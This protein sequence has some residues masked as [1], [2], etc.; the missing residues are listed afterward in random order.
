MLSGGRFQFMF[1]WW[2]GPTTSSANKKPYTMWKQQP[3]FPSG[4][5][6]TGPRGFTSQCVGYVPSIM[7]KPEVNFSIAD[8]PPTELRRVESYVFWK[9]EMG[10]GVRTEIFRPL[11][12]TRVRE[13][14]TLTSEGSE[15]WMFCDSS[16]KPD[17]SARCSRHSLEECGVSSLPRP[18]KQFRRST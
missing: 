12:N 16:R 6:T 8:H 9:I 5:F 3:L 10:S 2:N 15:H 7:G 18:S 17:D 4:F 14:A 13:A 11:C 1:H